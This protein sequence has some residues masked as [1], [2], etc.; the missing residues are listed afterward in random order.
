[1]YTVFVKELMY[2]DPDI[3]EMTGPSWEFSTWELE[4]IMRSAEICRRNGGTEF[5]MSHPISEID[6][7]IVHYD[8]NGNMLYKE[9]W[10]D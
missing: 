8:R 3:N 9:H 4:D 2:K 6:G 10:Y 1:M 5:L 7:V